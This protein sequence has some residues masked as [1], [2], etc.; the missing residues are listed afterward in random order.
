MGMNGCE[1]T[2]RAL[3]IDAQTSTEQPFVEIKFDLGRTWLPDASV[4]IGDEFAFG[5]GNGD[6]T[7]GSAMFELHFIPPYE[8]TIWSSVSGKE[9]G[10]RVLFTR[11]IMEPVAGE[12]QPRRLLTLLNK[13]QDEYCNFIG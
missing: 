8:P 1:V 5:M 3:K 13:Y 7:Y 2:A 4:P 12:T 9:V 11:F 6:T 10:R